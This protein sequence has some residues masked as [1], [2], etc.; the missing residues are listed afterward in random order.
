[1]RTL[2]AG[3]MVVAVASGASAPSRSV[4]TLVQQDPWLDP[5]D[6]PTSSV[7]ADGRYV[8]FTSY[9]RL[10]AA[11]TN[12]RRDIYVLDRDDGRVTLESVTPLGTVAEA[13]SEHPRLSGDGRFLVY[14][15]RLS[16][17]AGTAPVDILLRDRAEGTAR[18]LSTGAGGERANGASS[19]PAISQDGRHVV[20]ASHATNLVSGTDQ[21]GPAADIYAFDTVTGTL[22]RV[23]VDHAGLQPRVGGSIAPSV[24]ADGRYVAFASVA[25]LDGREV[26]MTVINGARRPVSSVYVRDRQRGTTTRV[27]ALPAGKRAPAGASWMPAISADGRFVAFVSNASLTADDGNRS[28]D[29]FLADLRSGLLTLVSRAAGGG[30]ANGSSGNPA[31][32]ADGSV[33]V[34]QSHASDILCPRRCDRETEDINLLWDVFLFEVRAGTVTRIS[35]APAGGWMEPSIGPAIDASGLFVVFSSRHPTEP[36][37]RKNDFD[38]FLCGSAAE[39]PVPRP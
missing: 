4:H 27:P 10:A 15:T 37:D 36:S 7:S 20:F 19:A 9:A 14:R 11:D 34:F 22:A 16:E 29:V 5:L 31:I 18:V 13:D 30:S 8:A 24:S 28:S 1:M 26:S 38:L 39:V 32:S 12:T 17:A 23:S 2:P 35:G 21:N 3:L 25:S 33:V 6:A